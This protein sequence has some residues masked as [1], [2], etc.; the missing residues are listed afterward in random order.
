MLP[1]QRV[2][3][4]WSGI[5]QTV[6]WGCFL[7]CP[8]AFVRWC[9]RSRRSPS[10]CLWGFPC[11][12]WSWL[13][14][15]G[16]SLLPS[17]KAGCRWWGHFFCQSLEGWDAARGFVHRLFWV[18]L[19]LPHMQLNFSGLLLAVVK[20]FREATPQAQLPSTSPHR[21]LTGNFRDRGNHEKEIFGGRL[22]V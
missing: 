18:A 6:L 9:Q 12:R 1:L 15:C 20:S 11:Q 10:P 8:V 19:L 14:A 16:G 5:A 17:P 2:A 13:P 7:P 3:S 21:V 22:S 4:A